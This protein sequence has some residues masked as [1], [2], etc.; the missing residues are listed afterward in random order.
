MVALS[1]LILKGM[2]CDNKQKT[3][4]T[5]AR[6]NWCSAAYISCSP[7]EKLRNGKELQRC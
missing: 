4:T 3:T 1:L 2:F 7:E 6:V 5:C